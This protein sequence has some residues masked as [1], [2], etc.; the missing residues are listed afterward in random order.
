MQICLYLTGGGGSIWNAGSKV[1]PE[2]EHPW[3][4][5]V[6]VLVPILQSI[7]IVLDDKLEKITAKDEE[8]N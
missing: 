5:L 3:H 7:S 6:D 4:T 8:T 1:Q 2:S